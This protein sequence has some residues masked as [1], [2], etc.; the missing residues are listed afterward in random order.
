M[1]L[2][3]H[4][5]IPPL[6]GKKG[7]FIL[8]MRE[9]NNVQVFFD[10]KTEYPKEMRKCLITGDPKNIVQ[11]VSMIEGRIDKHYEK[12]L[13]YAKHPFHS[14]SDQADK[15]EYIQF[16][17]RFVFQEDF[18]N[19]IE[20]NFEFLDAC[21]IKNVYFSTDSNFKV[22]GLEENE[23]VGT[24]SGNYV[25][26]YDLVNVLLSKFSEFCQKFSKERTFKIVLEKSHALIL[27]K[28]QNRIFSNFNKT[29][30]GLSINF[31]P[32]NPE[33]IGIFKYDLSEYIIS[34]E[35]PSSSKKEFIF[36]LFSQIKD[37]SKEKLEVK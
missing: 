23:K 3:P 12:C 33:E 35:G 27:S 22:Q 20:K 32:F 24:L 21:Q 34:I 14:S 19:F 37:V 8:E 10:I 18:F 36:N 4:C 25:E 11:A 6:I 28:D 2:V 29:I 1:M 16:K 30:K 17:F 5:M 13:E 15:I 26:I 31:V 7:K 9:H